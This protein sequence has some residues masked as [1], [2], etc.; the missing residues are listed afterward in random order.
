M[1]AGSSVFRA[2][3]AIYLPKLVIQSTHELLTSISHAN[4][5][6]PVVLPTSYILLKM[7][8]RLK[9]VITLL[10]IYY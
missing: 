3:F 10:L 2:P 6:L 5:L 8:V 1:K 9:N 4:T 7:Y